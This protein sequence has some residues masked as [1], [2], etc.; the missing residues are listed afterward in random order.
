MF[1]LFNFNYIKIAKNIQEA[2][3][4]NHDVVDQVIIKLVP[5]TWNLCTVLWKNLLYSY[6]WR[7]FTCYFFIFHYH[8]FMSTST[9][10]CKYTIQKVNTLGV[11]AVIEHKQQK[12]AWILS[13]MLK[14]GYLR[15]TMYLL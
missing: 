1:D 8:Y 2:R 9:Y 11:R 14:K 15:T 10:M 6:Q 13:Q 3:L 4:E 7:R 12:N 5:I